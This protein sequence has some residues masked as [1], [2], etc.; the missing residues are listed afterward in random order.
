MAKTKAKPKRIT[1]FRTT[2]HP[3]AIQPVERTYDWAYRV[4]WKPLNHAARQRA[5]H[6]CDTEA[7]AQTV[8][9]EVHQHLTQ[10]LEPP[11]GH[12]PTGPR[13]NPTHRGKILTMPDIEEAWASEWNGDKRDSLN[14]ARYNLNRYAYAELP[15]YREDRDEPDGGTICLARIPA[16][17]LKRADLVQ[18]SRALRFM[19]KTRG[20]GFI[21]DSTRALALRN[22]KT[23]LNFGL[24]NENPSTGEPFLT[25]NFWNKLSITVYDGARPREKFRNEKDWL[26]AAQFLSPVWLACATVNLY[27]GCR[28]GEVRGMTV[29]VIDL[30]E[31]LIFIEFAINKHGHRTKPKQ[32]A[33][34]DSVAMHK[35]LKPLLA[36]WIGNLDDQGPE[37]LLF[38]GNRGGAYISL[39]GFNKA[40]ARACKQAGLP[41]VVS[42]HGLRRTLGYWMSQANVPIEDIRATLR[43]VDVRTTQGY[44]E[45]TKESRRRA[46]DAV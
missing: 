31:E 12:A 41:Y 1:L 2:A 29:G 45:A 8:A 10:G 28:F 7:E 5:T 37:A 24:S 42:S 40:L 35:L 32:P 46:M 38:P 27:T 14:D 20:K 19:P 44:M 21:A 13:V 33:S 36:E 16:A 9:L 3:V 6:R 17:Q 22:L 30:V 39:T 26:A 18:W 34:E 23:V 25:K 15:T 11:Y 43:H 4:E